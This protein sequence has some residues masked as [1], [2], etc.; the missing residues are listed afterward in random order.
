MTTAAVAGRRE[1]H[2]R[3]FRRTLLSM[4]WWH[5][6]IGVFIGVVLTLWVVSGLIMILPVSDIARSGAGTGAPITWTD[7]TVSPA[8]AA[9]AALA[10]G[11]PSVRSLEL[12][13][14]RDGVAYL[15]RVEPNGSVLVDGRTG[16]VIT[17]TDSLAAAIAAD[18]VPGGIKAVRHV[19]R[20]DTPGNYS[21]HGPLPAYRV[22]FTDA[23]E[24]EAWVQVFTGDVRR[25]TAND[26][27][28]TVWG[29][30]T[31]VFSPMNDGPGG[32]RSRLGALWIT[33]I[34]SLIAMVAGYW[35]ALPARWRSKVRI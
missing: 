22:T 26:R 34:I 19:E 23:A 12:K 25:S 17:I 7:V 11:A 1:R 14:I 32:N 16:A 28:K 9:Q 31:H 4:R 21:G 3:R 15:V 29:H 5:N 35:L 27:F 24:T 20:V 33:S 2:H 8:Q 13:R 30:N 6:W 18:A 10:T